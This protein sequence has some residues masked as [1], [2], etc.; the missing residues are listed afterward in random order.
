MAHG[1]LS[2]ASF[3]GW[4]IVRVLTGA[5]VW[6]KTEGKAEIVQRVLERV[7]AEKAEATVDS[8]REAIF[9]MIRG[10][11]GFARFN[12]TIRDALRRS[13]ERVVIAQRR[14]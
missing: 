8:D 11:A 4:R 10:N 5:G 6:T 12:R 9:A 7:D 3:V 13:F 14:L 1:S 2:G